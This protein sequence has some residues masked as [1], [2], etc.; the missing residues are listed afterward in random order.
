MMLT[1]QETTIGYRMARRQK[2]EPVQV[3]IKMGTRGFLG[4]DLNEFY[5]GDICVEELL[6]REKPT[7]E[8]SVPPGERE[9]FKNMI[10]TSQSGSRCMYPG[11]EKDP[12]EAHMLSK[13]GC[14]S[15]LAR[16]NTVLKINEDG[17]GGKIFLDKVPVSRASTERCFC[18]EHDNDL[19]H[20]LDAPVCSGS[21]SV[22]QSFKLAYRLLCGRIPFAEAF[23]STME[24]HLKES[25]NAHRSAN[26]NSFFFDLK[27]YCTNQ[28]EYIRVK[29]LMD[30]ALLE[31]KWDVVESICWEVLTGKPI[32]AAAGTTSLEDLFQKDRSKD[33]TC[34]FVTALPEQ[35]GKTLVIVSYM[36]EDSEIVRHYL[37]RVGVLGKDSRDLGI[38]SVLSKLLLRHCRYVCISPSSFEVKSRNEWEKI[39]EYWYETNNGPFY[40]LKHEG[41]ETLNLFCGPRSRNI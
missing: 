38:S 12:V 3:P 25:G 23:L 27:R 37:K 1:W 6:R 18:V 26:S 24:T 5:Q 22:E 14:L 9:A 36:K 2:W 7:S 41:E 30:A 32:V 33:K 20:V 21:V 34:V 19:F 10:K 16:S 35:G 15:V 11:C 29:E 17:P 13:A 8:V 4:S 40:D 31:K 28:L 39:L